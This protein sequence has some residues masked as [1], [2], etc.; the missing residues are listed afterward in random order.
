MPLVLTVLGWLPLLVSAILLGAGWT[1]SW[2]IGAGSVRALAISTV[3]FVVAGCLQLF[4]ASVLFATLGLV[5]QVILAITMILR[6][7][8]QA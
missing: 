2:T 3:W 5:L 8:M 6:A 4:A 7:R 1:A